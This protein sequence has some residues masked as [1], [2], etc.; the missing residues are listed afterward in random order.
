MKELLNK[1]FVFRLKLLDNLSRERLNGTSALSVS[2]YA[3]KLSK[4]R[5]TILKNI[6]ALKIDIKRLGC[7]KYITI[8]LSDES[9]IFTEIT[10]DFDTNYFF[11]YY[12]EHS[13][14]FNLCLE[15]FNETFV[16]LQSFATKRFY[17]Y[18]TVYRKMTDLKKIVAQYDLTLDL[19][20]STLI[21]GKEQNI[22][23]FFFSLFWESYKVLEWPFPSIDFD[24]LKKTLESSSPE[25]Q[26]FLEKPNMVFIWFAMTIFRITNDHIIDEEF[27]YNESTFPM[28]AKEKF[29]FF[30]STFTKS[31]PQ[32]DNLEQLTWH[33]EANFLYFTLL[34]SQI[35]PLK[36]IPTLKLTSFVAPKKSRSTLITEAWINQFMNKFDLSLDINEYFYLYYN[37]LSLHS[38]YLYLPGPAQ[39]VNIFNDS[40]YADMDLFIDYELVYD[41]LNNLFLDSVIAPLN[42]QKQSL[43]YFYLLLI[44]ELMDSKRPALNIAVFSHSSVFQK[45]FFEAMLTKNLS[46]PVNFLPYTS[47]QVDFLITDVSLSKWLTKEPPT[48]VWNS[49]VEQGKINRLVSYLNKV[50]TEKYKVQSRSLN[51]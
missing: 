23:F 32:L 49:T 26:P 8:S 33:Y 51:N 25:V 41:F 45:D 12:L 48:F 21:Q 20:T 5:R 10:P 29:I 36:R 17:S 37:L 30:F 47:D 22:R 35:Y 28:L 3:S 46:F 16:D 18:S 19:N 44:S 42:S 15:I 4:D 50:Y 7:E 38:R 31:Y 13:I 1:E 14:L 39:I 9:T 40:S 24:K 34:T 43:I 27:D 11:L 6:E 2:D